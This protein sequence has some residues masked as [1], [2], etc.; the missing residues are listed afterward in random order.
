[1]SCQ[2]PGPGL[3][4]KEGHIWLANEEQARSTN[5]LMSVE[6]FRVRHVDK[7]LAT[8][9]V[10]CWR[11]LCGS[12]CVQLVH[13]PVPLK[14]LLWLQTCHPRAV[15]YPALDVAFQQQQLVGEGGGG[16]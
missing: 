7:R 5:R 8:P 11:R 10:E 2:Q 4:G 15:S 12:G 3:I 6:F 14:R 9:C 13:V 1:M 16:A